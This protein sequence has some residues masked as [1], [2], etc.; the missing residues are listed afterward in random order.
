MLAEVPKTSYREPTPLW[1]TM[2]IV[3]LDGYTLNPGDLSWAPLEALGTCT[4]H[5][6][7]PVPEIVSR[8]READ[9]ILT[10]KTPL[11]AKTLGQLPR[12][13]YVGVLATGFNVVDIE[14]ARARGI[15]VT[16]VPSYSTLSV[17]QAVFAHILNLTHHVG[18]HAGTVR[19]GAWSSSKDFCYW[20]F[21]P[22]EL[23]GLTM[24]IVGFGRIGQAVAGIAHAMGMRVIAHSPD[25][26][27]DSFV[28]FLALEEVF[29]QS[30]VLSLHCP[31]TEETRNIVNRR[32]L[33]IMQSSAFLINTGRGPLVDEEALAEA[34]NGGVIA[35][36]GLDVLSVEPPPPTNPLLTARNCHITP[37]L[38]WATRAARVRLLQAA[39]ENLRCFLEGRSCNVVNDV[40]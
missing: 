35:G 9:A 14:A 37:H 26:P 25:P 23:A 22:V 29:R 30:D 17:A 11:D 18:H 16:N 21:P 12:L 40:I 28:E 20:V 38:A 8:S 19:D 27:A 5:D 31:L 32:R 33:G 4:I 10:N 3:V 39:A 7:T 13:R 15:P 34:L 6:R 24:G 1:H 36:A 2:H